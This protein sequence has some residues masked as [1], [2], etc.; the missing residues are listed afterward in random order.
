VRVESSIYEGFEVSLFYDPMIAKLIVWGETRAEAILRMRRA[1]N[2]YRVGGI[3]TSIPFH[4]Q[5][6]DSTQFIRGQLDTNF[7]ED[8]FAISYL[9]KPDL[10]LTAAIAAALAV[11]DRGREA[12]V[13]RQPVQQ[14]GSAWKRPL[15][16]RRTVDML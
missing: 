3:K 8:R 10:E 7:L 5:I 15:G 2:E 6:M 4:L 13:Q 1:L 16:W 9:E 14:A 12:S 11:H